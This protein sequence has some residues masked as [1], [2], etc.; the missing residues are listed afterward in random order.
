[1]LTESEGNG[2]F[3]SLR[4]VCQSPAEDMRAVWNTSARPAVAETDR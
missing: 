4:D 1:M 2:R 3:W